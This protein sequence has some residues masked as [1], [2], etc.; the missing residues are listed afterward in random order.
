MGISAAVADFSNH[1]SL[2]LSSWITINS[3]VL[4]L[5]FL[6]GLIFKDAFGQNVHLFGISLGQL[7]IFAFPMVLLGTVLG[8]LIGFYIFPFGW[9]FNLA[10]TVGSILAATDPVAVAAL[11]EEVGAPPR[12]K[13]HVAGESLL[14]D[15][16]AIVFF[17]IFSE[18]YFYEFGIPGFGEDV[19][20]GKGIGM[21]A[22][23]ALGGTAVG[24]MFGLGLLGLLFVLNRRFSREE[25]VV[26]VTTVIAVAYL[27]YYVADFVL[28][29]SGVIATVSAGLIV[30]LLGRAMVNDLN[31]LEDFLTIIEHILNTILFTLGGA[32]WGAVIA[33]GESAGIWGSKE[34]GYLI[35]LYVLLNAIRALQFTMTC[36][37]TARIGLKTSWQETSFQIFGGLRGAVGIALAIALDN[38]VAEATG[39]LDETIDEIHTQQAFAMVGGIAFLTLLIN[40]TTA[41]PLLRKLGLADSSD[42]RKRIVEAYRLRIRAKFIDGMVKLLCQKRFHSVNFALV[43]FHV[44]SVSDLTTTQLLHAVNKYKESVP[45][46]EYTP[47]HLNRILPFVIDDAIGP[48]EEEARA[49]KEQIMKDHDNH[50][51]NTRIAKRAQN[52]R[53]KRTRR[54]STS[55]LRHMMNEDPLSAKEL[56]ILFIST[57]R[58]AYEKQIEEGELD[59][60]HILAVS[61]DQSLEFALDRAVKGGPL[62]DWEDLT[63]VHKPI[64]KFATA[65]KEFNFARAIVS[66]VVPT[67]RA[68]LGW[69][70]QSMNMYIEQSLSFM[71]A[72][73]TAQD[74]FKLELQ[75][76]DSQL[77]EAAKV[78]IEESKEQYK[79][80]EAA[81]HSYDAHTTELA[82][83]HK[84]C[85]ILLTMGIHWI[86]KLVK[87][88]LLK[89]SEAEPLI[90]EIEEHLDHVVSCDM[91]HH[92]GETKELLAPEKPKENS[93]ETDSVDAAE[94]EKP[95][96]FD[97]LLEA[98]YQE[99]ET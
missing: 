29:T 98:D 10:M 71:A 27:N 72:H 57:L 59:D 49:I 39:G 89:E 51:R 23:K 35:L 94:E 70:S 42:A 48:F 86:E 68:E 11:L 58:A 36:P 83:S 43:K 19:D 24:I 32:V 40:G 88:G 44:P 56:R 66:R 62:K 90:E 12:L 41:G 22:Q 30:K 76:V 64:T 28:K 95:P 46:E 4:L 99:H 16:S 31:L 25:N 82:I 33:T 8:A 60:A 97:P 91:D 77:N 26:Q 34:W 52:R 65:F 7:L 85:K 61:L 75:D 1:I 9:S 87:T 69:K 2:T 17:S 53:E 15:G 6:P 50:E 55:N 18:R 92:P 3:E 47:P 74:S 14:N 96:T 73:R 79:L 54:I 93:S 20:L 78:V 80:A 21:F 67:R 5:V 13:V 38:D 81:L 63:L 37:I 84:F 45:P